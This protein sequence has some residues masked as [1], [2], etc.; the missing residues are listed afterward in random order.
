MACL[1]AGAPDALYSGMSMACGF[2]VASNEASS[3][4]SICTIDG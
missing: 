3:N 2:S 4:D 1:V